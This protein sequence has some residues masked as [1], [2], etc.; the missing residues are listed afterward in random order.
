M[1]CLEKDPA[2]RYPNMAELEAAICE[3]Q[4]AAGVISEWDD[5]PLPDVD[6]ERRANLRGRMPGVNSRWRRRGGAGCC[7]WRRRSARRSRRGSLLLAMGS[8][9]VPPEVAAQIEALSKEARDAASVGHYVEPEPD[10]DA[11]RDHEDLRLE[12]LTGPGEAMADERGKVLRTEFSNQLVTVADKFWEQ[13]ATRGLAF[14]YYDW[15]LVFDGGQ[16]ARLERAPRAPASAGDARAPARRQAERGREV[17]DGVR[18]GDD[19]PRQE[20]GRKEAAMKLSADNRMPL[21]KRCW[22]GGG[23][24]GRVACRGRAAAG[25]GAGGE[26][27]GGGRRWPTPVEPTPVVEDPKKGGKPGRRRSRTSWRR[28]SSRARR[29]SATRRRRRSWRRRARRR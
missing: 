9:E 2:D 15:A 4:I 14:E 26:A 25:Q 22:R 28:A 24:R 20:K 13:E 27:A 23:A 1:R 12:A 3:A 8:P 7:R 11:G 17:G 21:S 19:Q 10:D 6:P 18:H 29:S 16:Q 5:L